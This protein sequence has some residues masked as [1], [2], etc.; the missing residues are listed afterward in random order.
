MGRSAAAIL[1]AGLAIAGAVVTAPTAEASVIRCGDANGYSVSAE[2]ATTSCAFALTVAQK[3]PARF[4]GDRT[5]V[6]ATSPVTGK[7]YEVACS[8]LYQRTLECTTYS[9]G[10]QIFLNS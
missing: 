6:I 3:L 5:S 2:S 1:A 9:T 10:V 4:K 7:R 8:R